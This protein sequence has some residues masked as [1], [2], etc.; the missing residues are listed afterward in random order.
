MKAMLDCMYENAFDGL[1]Y[2]E[3]CFIS[4]SSREDE[5]KQ[6]AAEIEAHFP[7]LDGKVQI[8]A[9]GPIIGAH[10]GPGTV[11]LFFWGKKRID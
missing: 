10:T 11:A 2:A 3:K 6:I 5:A 9:I 1:E 7:N 4:H 8:E